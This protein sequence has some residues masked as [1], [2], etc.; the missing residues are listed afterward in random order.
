MAVR[1]T[2]ARYRP[3][4]A[5]EPRPDG[6]RA[7][8]LTPVARFLSDDWLDVVRDAGL[9]VGEI[10]VECAVTGAPGSLRARPLA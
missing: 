6:R 4:R 3:P 7:D 5:I 10:T 8:S 1:D 2:G 9:S